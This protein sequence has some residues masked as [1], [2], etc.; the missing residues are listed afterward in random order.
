MN[1]ENII[2][3]LEINKGD[4]LLVTSNIIRI[5]INYKKKNITFDPNFLIDLLKEKVGKSGTLFFPT[6]NWDFCKGKTFNYYKLI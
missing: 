5:I 4:K 3:K 6:F 2:N 1:L